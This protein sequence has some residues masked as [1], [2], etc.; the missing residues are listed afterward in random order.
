[1]GLAFSRIESLVGGVEHDVRRELP[2]LF[3]MACTTPICHDLPGSA[4]GTRII[5]SRTP[6]LRPSTLGLFFH[7]ERG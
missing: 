5:N 6:L 3:A 7:F 4:C 1:M 2:L